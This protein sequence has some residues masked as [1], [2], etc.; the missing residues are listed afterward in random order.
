MN[1]AFNPATGMADITWNASTAG[2]LDH[3][4][5]RF[6]AGPDYDTELE[7]VVGNVPAGGPLTF[8]TA[9]G[10]AAEGNAAGFK[11]YTI[12]TTGNEKGSKAVSVLHTVAA[13][14]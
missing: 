8:S 6:V 13:E 11:V 12:T 14:P 3:Y 2:D 10:L 9:A 7:S 5:I 4:E 1:A